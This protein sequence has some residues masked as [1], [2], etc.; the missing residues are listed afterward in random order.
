GKKAEFYFEVLDD[1]D[2]F[3]VPHISIKWFIVEASDPQK[4]LSDEVTNYIPIDDQGLLNDK[5][6]DFTPDVTGV[7][8]VHAFVVHNFFTPAHFILSDKS[9]KP[10]AVEIKTEE[11][12]MA[13]VNK[14]AMHQFG[15]PG[16]TVSHT[17]DVGGLTGSQ[18]G[19]ITTGKLD[20]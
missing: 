18:T 15:Q 20:P 4:H 5:I 13:D 17:F 1:V 10:S 2:A 7:Y 16:K 14:E 11:E 8:Y 19:T 9:G 12:V 6:F 3:R